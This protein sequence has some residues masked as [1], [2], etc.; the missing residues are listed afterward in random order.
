[1]YLLCVVLILQHQLNGCFLL[2]IPVHYSDR[3]ELLLSPDGDPSTAMEGSTSILQDETV[4]VFVST[5]VLDLL[6]EADVAEVLRLAGRILRP[7]GQL[8]LTGESSS[9][10]L[11]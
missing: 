11:C 9:S 7:G 6:S 1:M 3:A 10:L 2:P 8:C 5:Y 4:D